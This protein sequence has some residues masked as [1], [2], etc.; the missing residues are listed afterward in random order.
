VGND[1]DRLAEGDV[2]VLGEAASST[3]IQIT[4]SDCGLSR[5]HDRKASLFYSL[6]LNGFN[7]TFSAWLGLWAT[8]WQPFGYF[9]SLTASRL[10]LVNSTPACSSAA[11]MASTRNVGRA[12]SEVASR[13]SD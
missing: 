7:G 8:L 9:R 5:W 12:N 3:R 2:S 1:T 13:M 4:N 11:F 6:N 10:P